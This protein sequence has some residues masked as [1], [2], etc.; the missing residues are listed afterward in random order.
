MAIDIDKIYAATWE[1]YLNAKKNI[2]EKEIFFDYGDHSF[3]N[4]AS[5]VYRIGFIGT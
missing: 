3:R 2:P 5:N 4:C 1:H